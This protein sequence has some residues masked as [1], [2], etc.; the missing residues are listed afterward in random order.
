[1]KLRQCR[2]C[3][4]NN[5]KTLFSLGNLSFTG[6]FPSKNQNIKKKNYYISYL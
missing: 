6:K 4:K 3:K 5:L 1:M 2:I